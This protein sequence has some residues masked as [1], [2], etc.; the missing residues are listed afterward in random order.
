VGGDSGRVCMLITSY[1]VRGDLDLGVR[2]RAAATIDDN[3]NK[4]AIRRCWRLAVAGNVNND[5]R[6]GLSPCFVD[7]GSS[8]TYYIPAGPRLPS[9]LYKRCTRLYTIIVQLAVANLQQPAAQNG[10]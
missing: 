7:D 6:R 8:Y 5:D 2:R 3:A 4:D 9:S 1:R 10:G